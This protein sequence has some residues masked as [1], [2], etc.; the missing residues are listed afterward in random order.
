MT[1]YLDNT[2]IRFG[3]KLQRQNM[4]I[5]TGYGCAPY[6][7]PVWPTGVQLLVF[8]CFS[9]S[10]I[11]YCR[12]LIVVSSLYSFDFCVLG[13]DA[14]IVRNPSR[15]LNKSLVYTTAEVRARL[16]ATSNRFKPP[17][18]PLPQPPSKNFTVVYY[19]W[20]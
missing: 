9:I 8:F 4:D 19:F 16:M 1:H 14:L 10:V 2:F 17:P 20:H 15:G 11:F 12:V 6:H 7:S 5:P 3:A 18:P 13:D